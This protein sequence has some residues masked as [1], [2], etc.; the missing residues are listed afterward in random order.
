M[1]FLERETLLPAPRETAFAFFHDPRNLRRITPKWLGFKITRIDELPVQEGFQISY[2]IR[3]LILPMSWTTTITE[4]D[5]PA[6]F[7]DIQTSGPYKSW[8][9]EHTFEE[10]DGGT[11]MRDRVQYELP[12]GIL[13]AIAHRL[14]VARQLNRIFDYRARRIRRIFAKKERAAV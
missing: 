2:R 14:I 10:V 7:A 13:G 6:R 9:H 12:F 3:P 8:R 4:W 5:P 11:M 1:P